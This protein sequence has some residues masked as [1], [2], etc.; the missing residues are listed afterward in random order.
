MPLIQRMHY[1]VDYVSFSI[2]KMEDRI[3]STLKAFNNKV[4][5]YADELLR[6][7]KLERILA[8][9]CLFIPLILRTID[10][11][12]R[13]SIS[14]YAYMQANQ[15]Y[16]F[17]LSLAAMLFV[18]NGTI[19]ARKWYNTVLGISLAGVALFPSL[20]FI[21]LHYS[22]AIVFFLGSTFVIVWYTSRKQ[23]WI[24]I[25]IALGIVFSLVFHFIFHLIT[26]L[27]AEWIAFA[28]IAVHYILESSKKLD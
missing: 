5:S 27:V 23:L 10:G 28:I 13:E 19:Y 20:D 9:L 17:L 18:V 3:M 26:L 21:Y 15:V 1:S 11:K 7:S 4:V 16:V 2:N 12:F 25:G 24:K 8:F 14:A 22:F 6:F